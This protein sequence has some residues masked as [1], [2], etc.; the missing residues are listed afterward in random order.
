MELK[1]THT[2]HSKCSAEQDAA[3]REGAKRAGLTASEVIRRGIHEICK[4][5]GVHYPIDQLRIKRRN[6]DHLQSPDNPAE[7]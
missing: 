4:I 3:L 7:N 1:S 2:H 6:Q 5:Y